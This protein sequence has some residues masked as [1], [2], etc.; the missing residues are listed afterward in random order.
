MLPDQFGQPFLSSAVEKF[1]ERK[2]VHIQKLNF[3]DR[4]RVR[5]QRYAQKRSGS[6]QGQLR[7][8]LG[9][10]FQAGQRPGAALDLIEDHQIQAA[11][12]G[13]IEVKL[14]F[15]EDSSRFQIL[16]EYPSESFILFEIDIM[17]P[18]KSRSAEFL[19][20]PGFAN[21]PGA[22]ENQGF[23]VYGRFPAV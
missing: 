7:H 16:L 15:F 3:S 9:E 14:Q 6:A 10:I 22:P 19:Q 11:V 17:M 20:Y 13:P 2:G 8:L 5:L 23:A 12:D 1:C 21:L 18:G 4:E